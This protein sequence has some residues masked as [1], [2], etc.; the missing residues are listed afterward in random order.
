V[1]GASLPFATKRTFRKLAET[2][3]LITGQ[4]KQRCHHFPKGM[5]RRRLRIRLS[6]QLL[7]SFWATANRPDSLLPCNRLSLYFPGELT[8]R[9]SLNYVVF[10]SARVNL[11]TSPMTPSCTSGRPGSLRTASHEEGVQL[12]FSAR[13]YNRGQPH[14]PVG[15]GVRSLRLLLRTCRR[16][17]PQPLPEDQWTTECESG[18]RAGSIAGISNPEQK[19]TIL[20]SG[21]PWRTA[22]KT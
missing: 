14:E 2:L 13:Q 11:R 4:V 10:R 5:G 8:Q 17:R 7:Q 3:G 15:T 21:S 1:E 20:K 22:G 18:C 16:Q 19:T 6:H 9:G 12:R